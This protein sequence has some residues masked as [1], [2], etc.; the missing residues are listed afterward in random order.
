VSGSV[1]FI[2]I[3]QAKVAFA[4]NGNQKAAGYA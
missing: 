1:E 3:A 2:E 4:V